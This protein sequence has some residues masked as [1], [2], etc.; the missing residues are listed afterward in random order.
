MDKTTSMLAAFEAGKLPS[1][2]QVNRFFDWLNDVGIAQIEP[3]ENTELSAKG[4]VLANDLRGVLDAYKQ[5]GIHK[6][7][8]NVL[9]EAIWHLTEGDL[10]VTPGAGA[11]KDQAL[12]D[13]NALRHSLRTLLSIVWSS[14]SSEGTS[15]VQDLLSILRLSL[16]DA[17]EVI[18]D[19]AGLAK[20]SLR[21]IEDE[22]QEG[23]RDSLGRDKQRMEEEKD[24]KIAWQHG[25]D[26]VKNAG[27]TVIGAAQSGSATVEEKAEK[28]T[29][30]LQEAY[31]KIF[32]RA[33]SDE[34]YRQALDT[35]FNVI[36]KR[37]DR[38][39]DAA[40]DPNVT[41]ASFIADPTPEQHIPKALTLMRV[42]IERLAGTE[43]EPLFQC[44]RGCSNTI[45]RDDELKAWFDDFVRTTRKNLAEPGYARSDE[46]QSKRRE[47]RVRWRTLLEKDEKWRA[48]VDNVKVELGKIDEGLRNDEDLN[49]LKASHQKLGDDLERGLTEVGKEAQT[50]MQAAIEQATWFWQ[51]LFKVYIPRVLSKM[52]DLPIPRTEYKDSDIEFVLEN[53]DISSLNVLPS[54]VYIRNITDVDIQT[55]AKPSTPS[56]TQVGT[57]THIQI[58]ALQLSLK[59]VSFC[60]QAFSV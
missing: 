12:D 24:A 25:M 28:T 21:H 27:T 18:E 30:R 52:R 53:L 46:A 5:L 41:L 4:R 9:Q 6:N 31:Y 32:D 14:A 29:S 44:A 7:S 59:D 26:T 51:D 49:R 10:T 45:V 47:L 2:Q 58:Q 33:Q 57:L 34:D 19:K 16:A 20:E 22:V 15:I 60:S 40:S 37:L 11:D 17:A 38:T 3:T 55:S 39:M 8:D 42:L 13:L 43:L 54:H 35:I 56:H 36:H 48:A 50:G 23:K 1:T